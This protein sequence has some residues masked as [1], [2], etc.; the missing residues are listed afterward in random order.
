[1]KRGASLVLML[2]AAILCMGMGGLGGMPEG[3][4]PETDVNIHAEVKDRAAL[5]PL[6]RSFPW[7]AKPH[8]TPCEGRG[9]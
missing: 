8:S 9:N 7:Q 3:T 4:I 2:V 6:S 1:M 5:S